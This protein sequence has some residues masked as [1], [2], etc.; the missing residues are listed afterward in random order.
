MA[1]TFS[2]VT[3]TAQSLRN[4]VLVT[5]Q[6]NVGYQPQPRGFLTEE[7]PALNPGLLFNVYGEEVFDLVSDIT[8]HFIE[9]NT[10]VNDQIALRPEEFTVTGFIGELNNQTPDA[11]LALRKV[12]DKLTII[13]SYTPSLSASALIAYNNAKQAYDLAFSIKDSAVDR[14]SSIND[15]NIQAATA[16]TGSETVTQLNNRINSARNQNK[17]Q[18]AFQQFYGYWR[19]RTLFTVQ[20]PWAIFRNMAIKNLRAIQD[21]ETRMITEF[22][23]TFKVMRFAQTFSNVQQTANN[24]G[25]AATNIQAAEE[26]GVAATKENPVTLGSFITRINNVIRRI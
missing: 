24:Q 17:Q 21:A 7:K 9:D 18:V 2:Q 10:V 8:D 19:N 1:N 23:V 16:F 22:R 11:L 15:T 14:W 26:K 25:R 20:T 4:L 3:S 5:P 12:A 6:V 13:S